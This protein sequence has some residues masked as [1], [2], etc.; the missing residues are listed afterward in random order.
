MIEGGNRV[1]L[2]LARVRGAGAER[3]RGPGGE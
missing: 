1:P 3:L 2:D